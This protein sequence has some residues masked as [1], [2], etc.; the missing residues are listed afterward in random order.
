MKQ[1]LVC[2]FILLSIAAFSQIQTKLIKTNAVERINLKKE[3][4][5]LPINIGGITIMDARQETT[6]IGYSIHKP[7]KQYQLKNGFV[8]DLSAW[9]VNYLQIAANNTN[10][11]RLLIN[12]KKLWV[13]DEASPIKLENGKTGL[14]NNGW[15]RGA[16]IK[17]EYYLQRDSL[18]IPI[19]RFDSIVH[20]EAFNKYSNKSIAAYITETLKLSLEKLLTINIDSIQL[21]KKNILLHDI[22]KANKQGLDY[23]IYTAPELKKGIY[24]TFE[25]FKMNSISFTDFEFRKGKLGDIVYVNEEKTEYPLRNIWGFCDGKDF[26][27]KSCNKY[28]K[29]VRTGNTFYFQGIKA[30]TQ[31]GEYLYQ[32]LGAGGSSST[33]YTGN[34]VAYANDLRTSKYEITLKYYQLDMENGKIY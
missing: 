5:Y 1:I 20:F 34:N 2:C 31:N 17:I 4:T 8:S 11:S 26:Y 19:Y 13:G 24:K 30:L 6:D 15:Y 27:I 3:K 18:F 16:V 32:S 28:S 23:P 21:P 14:A 10:K 22:E 9:F 12:I 7:I 25:D 29:L 33:Y